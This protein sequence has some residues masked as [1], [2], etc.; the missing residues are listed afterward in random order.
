MCYNVKPTC[1][2]TVTELSPARRALILFVRR[3]LSL[4]SDARV[5]LKVISQKI[6]SP[7]AS[8]AFKE[9]KRVHPNNN[10]HS[11][12]ASLLYSVLTTSL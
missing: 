9:V 7:S 2:D 1:N 12:T 4:N 5:V 6:T 3:F 11:N 10:Q 8:H